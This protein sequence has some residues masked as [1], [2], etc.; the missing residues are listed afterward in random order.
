MV[1]YVM[2]KTFDRPSQT[3]GERRLSDLYKIDVI[4]SVRIERKKYV[5]DPGNM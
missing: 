4:S 3:D 5:P 1:K 2:R